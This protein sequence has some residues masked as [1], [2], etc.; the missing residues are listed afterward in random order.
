TVPEASLAWEQYPALFIAEYRCIH[1]FPRHFSDIQRYDHQRTSHLNR[2]APAAAVYYM[3]GCLPGQQQLLREKTAN[4]NRKYV[5]Q[6]FSNLRQTGEVRL[7]DNK[8]RNNAADAIQEFATNN[9]HDYHVE[10]SDPSNPYTQILHDSK[11]IGYPHF[12]GSDLP[13]HALR[14]GFGRKI[15]KAQQQKKNNRQ[16]SNM[17]PLSPDYNES[18]KP[19]NRYLGKIF[20]ALM[21][22]LQ[23][24]QHHPIHVVARHNSNKIVIDD[25]II[26][27][28]ETSIPGGVEAECMFYEECLEVPDLSKKF[29]PEITEKFGLTEDKFNNYKRR[30]KTK[31]HQ[32]ERNQI[33]EEMAV[34]LI[35][36]KER[37][38]LII[39]QEA[40]RARG[41]YLIY[42][43][44]DAKYALNPIP[45]KT[46]NSPHPRL[47]IHD[48]E[49]IRTT[50]SQRFL[51]VNNMAPAI[52]NQS[53]NSEEDAK[54]PR[55]S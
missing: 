47:S 11:M 18:G 45:I 49:L 35:N 16:I 7:F 37:K 33:W 32:F 21:T 6:T 48:K 39:A 3:S 19:A 38:L 28:R 8:K 50:G 43:H 30:F 25:R 41:G 52:A 34:D 46:S 15:M 36:Y 22:P 4:L 14:Y 12:A 5:Q 51:Q 10:V 23:M 13:Q 20:I 24:A 40:A 53:S 1:Y 26:H 44:D 29:L 42:R 55:P 27:E 2:I 17:P 54:K 31:K 9:Y